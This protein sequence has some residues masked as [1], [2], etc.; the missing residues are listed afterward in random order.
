MRMALLMM[1][2]NAGTGDGG[3][4]GECLLRIAEHLIEAT[5]FVCALLG[6]RAPSRHLQLVEDEPA[7]PQAAVPEPLPTP[8]RVGPVRVPRAGEGPMSAFPYTQG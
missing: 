5:G 3:L 6:D 4:E 2:V 7:P 8:Q 1:L